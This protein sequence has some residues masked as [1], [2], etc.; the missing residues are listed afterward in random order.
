MDQMYL[1]PDEDEQ[2]S[3]EDYCKEIQKQFT[4]VPSKEILK[5]IEFFIFG[6]L[7]AYKN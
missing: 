1:A 6:A 7:S 2:K 3:P 5:K 4:K